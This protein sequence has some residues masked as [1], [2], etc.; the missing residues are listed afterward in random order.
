M[1]SSPGSSESPES[2]ELHAN[3]SSSF[4][5]AAAAST[6]SA[7]LDKDRPYH[8]KRPHKKSRTGCKNCKARKVKCDEARPQ[9]RYC[10]LRKAECI[11]PEPSESK[12][13]TTSSSAARAAAAAAASASS[14]SATDTWKQPHDASNRNAAGQPPASSAPV[15]DDTPASSYCTTP[16]LHPGEEELA[17]VVSEPQFFPSPAVDSY[18]MR[19]LWFFTTA[20]CSS[21]SVERGK[22]RPLENILRT[23]MVQHAFA[24]PFLLDS[25]FAL[26]SLHMQQLNQNVDKNR[27]LMYRARSYEGYRKAVEGGRPEDYAA[28]IGNSLLLTAL[29]AQNFRDPEAKDLYIIDWLVV[30]RG[31]GLVIESMGMANFVKSGL[32]AL[33]YRPALNH[34]KA[35]KAIPNHLLFMITSIPPDDPD[36]LDTPTYYETLQCLGSLYLNLERGFGPIM[37]LRIITWF[38][39][40]PKP[41]ITLAREMRPRALI[42]LTYYSIF[43][44]LVKDIWWMG[45]VGDRSLRDLCAHIGRNL[46]PEWQSFLLA[47]LAALPLSDR[48]AI[49]RELLG[50]P[51]WTE[52]TGVLAKKV[53]AADDDEVWRAPFAPLTFLDN[54]G[55][56]VTISGDNIISIDGDPAP[57]SSFSLLSI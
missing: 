10:R 36:Y 4:H 8:S 37:N 50:D 32:H 33:F 56:V 42:I 19:L 35:T 2:Y 12:P 43:L 22:D 53:E 34:D 20:T 47:P 44:K 29:S 9:C 41:F 28:M 40:L 38:T 13:T 15:E 17:L 39:F 45:G 6:N 23:R 57:S 27:S 31:I 5:N 26:S 30:W 1:S 48:A 7:D 52:P 54:A 55:R 21:F 18:D 46:G 24:S 11:Y 14:A 49:A 51:S 3:S 25:L 16:P